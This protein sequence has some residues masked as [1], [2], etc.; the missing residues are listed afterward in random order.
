MTERTLAGRSRAISPTLVGY[1]QHFLS[2]RVVLKKEVV[3]RTVIQDGEPPETTVET[4]QEQYS[5]SGPSTTSNTTSNGTVVTGESGDT[6][7]MDALNAED[8]QLIKKL[9][10]EFAEL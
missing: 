4:K 6:D 9:E 8:E 3:K 2:F 5:D 10:Q 1:V 7:V